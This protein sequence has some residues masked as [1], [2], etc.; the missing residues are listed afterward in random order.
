MCLDPSWPTYTPSIMSRPPP[1]C[2]YVL[3]TCH[4]QDLVLRQTE[5]DRTNRSYYG[6]MGLYLLSA[7][8]NFD[9][10]VTL[11]KEGPYLTLQGVRTQK[12]L[13][14]SMDVGHCSM[15]HFPYSLYPLEMPAKMFLFDQCVCM[16]HNFGSSLTNYILFNPQGRLILLAGFGNIVGKVDL[17]DCRSLTC[18]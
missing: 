2:Q 4:T 11:D 8:C 5:V 14:S 9:C 6:E 12:N 17:F 18:I 1:T 15:C 7:A 3:L 13:V 16:L 10:H